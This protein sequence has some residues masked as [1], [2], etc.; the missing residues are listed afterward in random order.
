MSLIKEMFLSAFSTMGFAIL[1]RSP[2]KAIFYAGFV[3]AIAWGVFSMSLNISQNIVASSFLAA[4]TV[5]ILGEFF[6][7]YSKKPATLYVTPGIVPLVPGAGMYYTMIALIENDY[8]A[9]ITKGSETFFIA[10]AISMGIIVSSV[11]SR[12]IKRVKTKI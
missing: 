2:K 12:S 8:A 7:R 6:A 5:G 3:G 1:F 10:A 4:L 9:A 11:F